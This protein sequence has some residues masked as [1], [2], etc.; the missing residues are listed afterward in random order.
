MLDYVLSLVLRTGLSLAIAMVIYGGALLLWQ[1]GGERVDYHI[2]DGQPAD[3]KTASTI[4]NEALEGNTLSIIHLGIIVL[5]ATPVARVLSCLIVFAA[6][7]DYLYVVLS[8][9]VLGIL[10]YANL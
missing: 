9:I 6:E 1:H 8:A 5:I 2:F 4:F 3:L 7:R 10:L